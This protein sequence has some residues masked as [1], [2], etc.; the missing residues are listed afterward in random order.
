MAKYSFKATAVATAVSGALMA[1]SATAATQLP[2]APASSQVK[3]EALS[4]PQQERAEAYLVV[5]KQSTAVD[6][7]SEG[8]YS[9]EAA[10]QTFSSVQQAQFHMKEQIR[11]LDPRV[12]ILGSTKVLASTLIV[13]ASED[14]LKA[15]GKN[16]MVERIL[17]LREDRLFVEASS[18]YIGATQVRN[19]L[20]VT[21]KGVRA[22]VLDTGIDYT[23][24]AFNE[25]AGT[26]DDYKAAA[27]DPATVSWPQGIVVGGYDYMRDDPDP[28]EDDPTYRPEADELSDHGTHVSHDL[29]GIAPDVELYVY[30][31]CGGGCPYDAQVKALESAMDPNGD[32]DISDR[33]DLM[34]MSLGSEFG[35]TDVSSGTAYL[36]QRAVKLGTN[37]II[38][39]G[40]DDDVPFRVGGPSTTPN[41]LSVASLT[42]P[43][44]ERLFGE[45]TVAGEATVVQPASFGPQV[46]FDFTQ[47]DAELVYPEAN[48]NGCD[49]DEDANPFADMD[50]TG[51]AVLIDRG[52]CAF[53]EKVLNAQERGAVFV[54]IANNNDD[55]TPAPMGGSNDAVT[56][57]SAGLNFAAGAKLKEQMKDGGK[58]TYSVSGVVKASPGGVS[59]F[60]SRGP[61]MDGLLKPEIAA[62][63]SNILAAAPGTGDQLHRKSGTS[64]S[65]PITAGA[66]ALVKQARPELD[67]LAVKAILMNTA[68]LNITIES[69]NVNPDSP[70]APIS[71]IGAGLVDVEKAIA[72]PVAAW[73]DLPEFDTKQAALSFGAKRLAETQTYTK[74]VVVRNYSDEARTYDLRMEQR[75]KNDE[76][77]GAVTF[78]HPAQVIVPAGQTALI[79]VEMT[80]DPS[81][82]PEFGVMNPFDND[83]LAKSVKALD[84][85]EYDGAL[86]FDDV[87]TD[88]NHDLHVVYHVLP[89]AAEEAEFSI[90]AGEEMSSLMVQ[91]TGAVAISGMA[92][93]VVLTSEDNDRR[94][95]IKSVTTAVSQSDNC[96]S[97]LFTTY[98]LQLQDGINH[99]RQAGYR[100]EF[101]LNNDGIADKFM[102]HLNDTGNNPAVRGRSRT[103]IGSIVNGNDEWE[104]GTP[105]LHE[106]GEATVTFA[107]CSELLGLNADAVGMPIGVQAFVGEAHWQSGI[108]GTPTD[109]ANGGFIFG[110]NPTVSLK[111]GEGEALKELAPGAKAMVEFDMPFAFTS[112]A[113][114]NVMA[115]V[116][117][118]LDVP[119]LPDLVVEGDLSVS[120]NAE[121]MP[122]ATITFG[123]KSP[124]FPILGYRIEGMHADSFA[125]DDK[126]V[127]SLVSSEN[128]DVEMGVESVELKVMAMDTLGS[129]TMTDVEIAVTN[130]H[131]EMPV[132]AHGQ[133]FSMMDGA[134][135]GTVVGKLDYAV[136]ESAADGI[137]GGVV[138]GTDLFEINENGELVTTAEINQL[139]VPSYTFKVMVEDSV[140]LKSEMVEVT[141]DVVLNPS[142]HAPVVEHGQI[143]SVTE[144][145][146]IGTVIGRLAYSDPD[147]DVSPVTEFIVTGTNLFTVDADGAIRVSGEIDFEFEKEVSFQVQARDSSL[148]VSEVVTVRVNVTNVTGGDDNDDNDSGSLAW[149]TLLAAPF[150]ALRRRKR[151]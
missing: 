64:M 149:L 143:F 23:H 9:V 46:A 25:A 57:P 148:F 145:A 112:A 29:T 120:E 109:S 79:D 68:D 102:T 61:S 41:A 13:Q 121:P 27:E 26:L 86:I 52:A 129:S 80:I 126:G 69:T 75:Y 136:F 92:E 38:S 146:Q 133:V 8:T 51:K 96:D 3:A 16:E 116:P 47:D 67:A 36:I 32:G 72:S 130:E 43:T 122:V 111:D 90:E 101:D 48:Q 37:M 31:V 11:E 77:S 45:A 62:P 114:T 99:L 30:S 6:L 78:K 131:D 19:T 12:K 22:A 33:V 94:F 100:L 89:K 28:I 108:W 35:D 59:D 142:V 87:A 5:L 7:M 135:A 53:T 147:A 21:G 97:G 83:E 49:L 124:A 132:V 95:D 140:G 24:K 14:A 55:G 107:A 34:N 113:G 66:V 128:L 82:L 84:L 10:K 118:D 18:D 40:N 50:F 139:A 115:V 81:K 2:A 54:F 88:G 150:A 103:L 123:D 17:P 74:S 1:A 4:N 104:W 15:L 105:M 85:A 144:N 39:A 127:I 91:N 117:G 98:S 60:S 44:F 73:V 110:M 141:V 70:L 119:A 65:G 151:K 134:P 63:G 76:D 138:E 20:D 93:Q 137:V 42:H 56:I 125:I 106:S 58:A 71:R